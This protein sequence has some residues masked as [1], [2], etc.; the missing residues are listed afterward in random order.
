M[1][2]WVAGL[3]LD[4]AGD[5]NRTYD[6]R[7]TSALLYR[8]SYTGD[9]NTI[10]NSKSRPNKHWAANHSQN[11]VFDVAVCYAGATI[12]P[13][14][15]TASSCRSKNT[16]ISGRTTS[17]SFESVRRS[18]NDSGSRS[19]CDGI[20]RASCLAWER[21]SNFGCS[22]TSCEIRPRFLVANSD[23]GLNRRHTVDH[24]RIRRTLDVV[25]ISR[26][27]NSCQNTDDRNH[28]HQL[29]QSEAFLHLVHVQ[30]SD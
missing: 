3:G 9:E 12:S 20:K 14:K 11:L 22:I 16:S 29:D 17:N 19:N 7:V 5:R 18:S 27:R 8:L 24:F 2:L 10:R 4:G 26:Q 1:P 21:H 30:S 25:L 28:D 15:S 23:G 13:C 6:L